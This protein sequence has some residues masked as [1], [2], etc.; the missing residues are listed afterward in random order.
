M[1]TRLHLAV[2][3]LE[4]ALRELSTASSHLMVDARGPAT[5]WTEKDVL[6]KANLKVLESID[7]VRE[8]KDA[9]TA[10]NIHLIKAQVAEATENPYGVLG[11]TDKRSKKKAG[12]KA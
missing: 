8:T 6:S 9:A 7:I 3:A 2:A 10:L 11:K 5:S 4:A 12:R 1:K